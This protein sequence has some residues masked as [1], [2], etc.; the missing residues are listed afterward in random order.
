MNKEAVARYGAGF[1]EAINN[2]SAPAQALATRAL[3]GIQGFATSGLV[4][5]AG[6]SLARPVLASDAG[7]TRT[8]RVELAAGGHTVNAA[9][10]ARDEA[11]LLALL[12][13]AKSRSA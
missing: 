8:V 13:H 10:D 7:P 5:P 9:V 12:Q 4:R 3:A 6:A 2:L 11:R 1:F